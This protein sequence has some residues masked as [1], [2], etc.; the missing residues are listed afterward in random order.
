[1]T[2]LTEV[3]IELIVKLLRDEAPL[4]KQLRRKIAF[5][6]DPEEGHVDIGKQPIHKKLN[7][8][9]GNDLARR[10]L[11]DQIRA[12]ASS[13]IPVLVEGERGTGKRLTARTIHETDTQRN[14]PFISVD[15]SSLPEVLSESQLLGQERRAFTRAVAEKE[16]LVEIACQGT[17]VFNEVDALPLRTQIVLLRFLEDKSI[18]HL[19]SNQQK[20]VDA[21]VIATSNRDLKAAVRDGSFRE[22]L[23]VHISAIKLAIPPL[24]ERRDDIL[25]LANFFHQKYA[26]LNNMRIMGFSADALEALWHHKWPGNVTELENGIKGA[27]VTARG[28][29]IRP[30][31]LGLGTPAGKIQYAGMNLKNAREKFLKD[32]ILQALSKNGDNI[33]KTAEDLGISRPT[34][35]ELREKL[36]ISRP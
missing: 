29:K 5:E 15:C 1:M 34:L 18:I 6:D 19:E 4:P 10:G 22:D 20:A 28:R 27:V 36:K 21:R 9:I 2:K 14:G 35:Y 24:R 3:E 31:D 8:L 23:Y 13:D 33:T 12:T 17:I 32:L 7:G 26:T 30:E 25:V 16:S 11:F